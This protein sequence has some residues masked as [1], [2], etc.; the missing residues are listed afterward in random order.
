[1]VDTMENNSLVT[2]P[3]LL[4]LAPEFDAK[5]QDMVEVYREMTSL[6]EVTAAMWFYFSCTV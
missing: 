3:S 2:L 6:A 4:G 5:G 1:M